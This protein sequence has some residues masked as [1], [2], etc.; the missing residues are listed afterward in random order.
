MSSAA[1]PAGNWREQI[2]SE[3]NAMN[4]T[5]SDWMHVEPFL[6]EAMHTLDET[7]RAAVL[8]RYFETNPPRSRPSL[9]NL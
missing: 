5:A 4:A 3:M 8:L 1:N 9:G 6:D 7:D 2:A